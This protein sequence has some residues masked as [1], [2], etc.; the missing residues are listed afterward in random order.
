MLLVPL[1]AGAELGWEEVVGKIILLEAIEEFTLDADIEIC[2]DIEEESPTLGVDEAPPPELLAM[3]GVDD[4][5][6]EVDVVS[7]VSEDSNELYKEDDDGDTV[8]TRREDETAELKPEVVDAI[9][10]DDK[11]ELLVLVP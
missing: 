11:P 3:E 8:E 2:E 7:E 5:V 1:P 4:T 6:C 9:A 10:L